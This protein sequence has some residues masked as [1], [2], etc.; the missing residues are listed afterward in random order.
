MV[1]R[2]RLND[3]DHWWCQEMP[4]SDQYLAILLF[5]Y[6]SSSSFYCR[7]VFRDNI[8]VLYFL[9]LLSQG[10]SITKLIRTI[11]PYTTI[12]HVLYYKNQEKVFDR[13]VA[14]KKVTN[15][16]MDVMVMLRRRWRRKKERKKKRDRR[17]V[18]RPEYILA[19]INVFLFYRYCYCSSSN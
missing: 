2:Q 5:L 7:Y 13:S 3:T 9:L 16:N 18:F 17:I 1:R 11:K 8:N 12:N 10:L 15:T 6:L 19:R 4:D 14:K